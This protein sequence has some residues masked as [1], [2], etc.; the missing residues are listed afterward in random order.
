MCNTSIPYSCTTFFWLHNYKELR[1]CTT[2]RFRL[3]V[4]QCCCTTIWLILDSFISN[5][6]TPKFQ[7]SNFVTSGFLRGLF[8]LLNWNLGSFCE[9]K[10]GF[11]EYF[12]SLGC[13]FFRNVSCAQK[14]LFLAIKNHKAGFRKFGRKPS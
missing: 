2:I 1:C 8:Q 7:F 5:R 6:S 14:S 13:F 12:G 10:S 4:V 3:I 11:K 9:T